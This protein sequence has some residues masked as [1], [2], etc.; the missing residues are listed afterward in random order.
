MILSSH[1]QH[2]DEF[3][4]DRFLPSFGFNLAGYLTPGV[5]LR[6]GAAATTF[7]LI[8]LAIKEN[9]SSTF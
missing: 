6:V 7:A 2:P 4:V 9:A 3:L 5:S 8:S 1:Q